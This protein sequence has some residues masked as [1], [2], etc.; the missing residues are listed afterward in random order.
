MKVGFLTSWNS[1]CGISEYTRDL[2]YVVKDKGIDIKVCGNFINDPVYPDE[3][4]VKRL[5]HC[6]FMTQKTYSDPL[7]IYEYLKDCNIIHIQFETSLYHPSWF[8]RL[9][10][11]FKEF[12]PNIKIVMTMHSSG[13]WEGFDL[14]LVNKYITHEPMN[15]L[16]SVSIP[17]GVKFFEEKD[18][19]DKKLITSF[20]LG[21]NRNDWVEA[22]IADT[23]IKFK[24]SFGT[25]KWH[26]KKELINNIS[27]G[28]AISL[29]YPPVGANVSSSACI[30]ALGFDRPLIISE[31]N[32]FKHII[33]LPGVYPVDDV[34]ELRDLISY[35]F[36]PKNEEE[37]KM[38]LNFRKNQII[39]SGKTFNNFVSSHLA[40]YESLLK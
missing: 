38:R 34:G 29:I 35:L 23:D 31:T 7:Q 19:L 24:T 1:R 3:D 17:M 12:S 30:F 37:I 33:D 20:G 27:E 18:N 28:W 16:N 32:W 6:P 2:V 25:G 40:V 39:N 14:S 22:A 21:R 4:F 11:N 26:T 36:D 9:L 8:P 5:F 15:W 13:I 10:R